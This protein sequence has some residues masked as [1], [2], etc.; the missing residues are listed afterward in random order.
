[1]RRVRKYKKKYQNMKNKKYGDYMIKITT[2]DGKIIEVDNYP[3]FQEKLIVDSF[4]FM[5]DKE[6]EEVKEPI[7]IPGK[8]SIFLKDI[9]KME[10][11]E[12][13]IVGVFDCLPFCS[14]DFIQEMV[15]RRGLR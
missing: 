14:D 13:S 8:F 3:K 7:I 15:K 9:E 4:N 6:K 1:M 11:I 5:L 12:E 2:K 10:I